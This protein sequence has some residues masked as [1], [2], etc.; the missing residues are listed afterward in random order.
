MGIMIFI[1]KWRGKEIEIPTSCD[2]GF[3]FDVILIEIFQVVPSE[4]VG[5][6][7]R[8]DWEDFDMESTSEKRGEGGCSPLFVQQQRQQPSLEKRE[9][10]FQTPSPLFYSWS[11]PKKLS[12]WANWGSDDNDRAAYQISPC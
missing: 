11:C 8:V 12:L 3:I 10:I 6:V 7:Y 4:D 9:E 1:P 2:E 5:V